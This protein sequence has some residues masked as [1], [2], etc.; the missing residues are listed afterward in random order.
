MGDFWFL[1]GRIVTHGME[2]QLCCNQLKDQSY[3]RNAGSDPAPGE[4]ACWMRKVLQT[5]EKKKK[6]NI[7]SLLSVMAKVKLKE[8]GRLDLDARN[9]GFQSAFSH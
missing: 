8:C 5:S 7:R 3:Q 9:L 2:Q 1:G 4:P 6:H